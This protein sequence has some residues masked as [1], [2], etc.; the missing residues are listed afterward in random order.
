MKNMYKV[1]KPQIEII[2]S[3]KKGPEII[4]NGKIKGR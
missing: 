4:A 2:R 1:K 3:A